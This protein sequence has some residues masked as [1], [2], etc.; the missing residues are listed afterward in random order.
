[1]YRNYYEVLGISPKA[2]TAE[3]KKAYRK[4]AMKYHPD[5]NPGVG[6]K[7]RFIEISKAYEVLSDP[8]KRWRYDLL[9]FPPQGSTVRPS[10]PSPPPPQAPPQRDS[11]R[12]DPRYYEAKKKKEA[13]EHNEFVQYQGLARIIAAIALVLV[14]FILIERQ[15][16]QTREGEIVSIRGIIN[17]KRGNLGIMIVTDKDR[18]SFS[19][20]VGHNIRKGDSLFKTTTPLLH[21]ITRIEIY[22]SSPLKGT[23]LLRL[24]QK[25]DQPEGMIKVYDSYY[26]PSVFNIFLFVPLIALLASIL[27]FGLPQKYS[28]LRFQFGLMGGM[29]GLLSILFLIMA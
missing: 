13:N 2:N 6:A 10:R 7:E 9:I 23:K 8:Q 1:M 19:R 24:Y 29:F 26:R 18:Y 15:G 16:A 14:A 25:T 28:R 20:Q 3:I 27:V 11:S 4:L 12:P 17:L 5:S 21:K 22:R